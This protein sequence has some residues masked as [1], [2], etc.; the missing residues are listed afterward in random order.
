MIMMDGYFFYCSFLKIFKRN[1]FIK[2]I[3][4]L[5]KLT[6][7]YNWVDIDSNRRILFIDDDD[8]DDEHLHNVIGNGFLLHCF[9]I[10]I[11]HH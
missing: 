3:A 7:A 8:D 5:T 11:D 9:L 6:R 1:K 2:K 10:I 4:K